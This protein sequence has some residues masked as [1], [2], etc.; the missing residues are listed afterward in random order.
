MAAEI[1]IDEPMEI[2]IPQRVKDVFVR[3]IL[4]DWDCKD[5]IIENLNKPFRKRDFHDI[6]EGIV[7]KFNSFVLKWDGDMYE[8]SDSDSDEDS[9]ED[10]D[11][12]YKIK[13]H[14]YNKRRKMGIVLQ[15]TLKYNDNILTSKDITTIAEMQQWIKDL[16]TFYKCYDCNTITNK[17]CDGY[18]HTCYKYVIKMVDDCPI[19]LI[20]DKPRMWVK[21]TCG[22]IFHRFCLAKVQ[23][24]ERNLR[25][26]LCRTSINFWGGSDL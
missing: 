11:E 22:H 2:I 3:A 12:M 18:C 24:Q 16:P 15:M 8:I 17:I 4:C 10:L 13:Y 21:T 26:P 19:C 20:N 7:G 6:I 14:W 1:A 23:I 5:K 25:C 9:D